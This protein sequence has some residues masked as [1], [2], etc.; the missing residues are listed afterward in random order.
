MTGKQLVRP[1]ARPLP[2]APAPPEAG[3]VAALCQG[4]APKLKNQERQPASY[5]RPG[6]QSRA[7]Q[8]GPC[9]S[10]ALSLPFFGKS[11][12]LQGFTGQGV[13]TAGG[14]NLAFDGSFLPVVVGHLVQCEQRAAAGQRVCEAEFAEGRLHAAVTDA[15]VSQLV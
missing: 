6:V 11:N 7:T 8:A 10:G 12:E 15:V 2:E 13:E 5:R 1:T 4:A 3:A 9:P 14:L